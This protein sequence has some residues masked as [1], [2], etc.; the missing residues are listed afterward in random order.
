MRPPCQLLG[1]LV[2]EC[3][4]A[5]DISKHHC[6]ADAGQGHVEQLLLSQDF[7]C[8]PLACGGFAAYEPIGP[9]QHCEI[10]HGAQ[11]DYQISVIDEVY[12][13]IVC[14]AEDRFLLG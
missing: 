2:E 11:A 13:F 7:M 1:G 10:E 9:K 8:G 12:R 6:I 3:D 14:A 5:V 4:P